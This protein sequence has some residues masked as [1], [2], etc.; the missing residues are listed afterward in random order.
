MPFP[1]DEP[2]VNVLI[3]FLRLNLNKK[4]SLRIK[5]MT[6]PGICIRFVCTFLSSLWSPWDTVGTAGFQCP[7]LASSHKRVNNNTNFTLPF[8]ETG[9]KWDLEENWLF[10]PSFLLIA[11]K[12]LLASKTEGGEER[13]VCLVW[14]CITHRSVLS[15]PLSEKLENCS[16]P[17][18]E[19]EKKKSSPSFSSDLIKF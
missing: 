3:D 6:D 19:R 1:L 18:E 5:K 2:F 8:L 12:W 4:R 13:E 10:S 9:G 14:V 16:F 7:S 11:F 15:C 17:L